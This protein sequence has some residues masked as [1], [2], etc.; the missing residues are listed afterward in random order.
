MARSKIDPKMKKALFALPPPRKEAGGTRAR[1]KVRPASDPSNRS[2]GI[3]RFDPCARCLGVSYVRTYH[4]SDTFCFPWREQA[5]WSQ[6]LLVFVVV[7]VFVVFV[8]FAADQESASRPRPPAFRGRAA[9]WVRGR[10]D[11]EEEGEEEE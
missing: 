7:F 1:V 9:V 4:G 2:N 10:G 6:S 3:Q 8:V 5:V 11:E